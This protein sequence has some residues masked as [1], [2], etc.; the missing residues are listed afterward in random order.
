MD[1]VRLI[2]DMYAGFGQGRVVIA[3]ECR[4]ML[5]IPLSGA[6]GAEEA[7]LEVDGHFRHD[8]IAVLILG[9]RY[10]DSRQ[11]VLL[12]VRTQYA[13]GQLATGE[14]HGFV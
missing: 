13:Y 2:G 12:G 1:E 5:R 6:V 9:G 14:N 8:G 11:Q 3:V 7:V 4:E 10:L